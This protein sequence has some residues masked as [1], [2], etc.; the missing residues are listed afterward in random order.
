MPE[1]R[2]TFKALDEASLR[3]PIPLSKG[4]VGE[5]ESFLAKTKEISNHN[6]S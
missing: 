6:I 2:E 5:N 3:A 4:K 1:A